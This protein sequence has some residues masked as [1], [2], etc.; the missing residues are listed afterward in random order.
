MRRRRQND[1]LPKYCQRRSYGVIYTP[2]LSKG[3][4]GKPINLGPSDM[5]VRDAW[6]AYERVTAEK[7]DTLNWLLSAYHDSERYRSRCQSTRDHYDAYRDKLTACPMANGKLFGG[8]RLEKIKRTSIQRYLDKHHAPILANRQIQYLKAAWNWAMNRY[9]HMPPNPCVGLELNV[10]KSRD[11]YIAPD[12]YAAIHQHTTG[13][14]TWAMELAY[15]C[16]AR[17]QEVLALRVR[18]M[19]PQGLR[20]IRSKGSKGEIT[21]W[22]PRLRAAVDGALAHS[23]PRRQPFPG[24]RLLLNNRGRPIGKSAWNSALQRLRQKMD[25]LGI[26]RFTLHD[27]KAAGYSDQRV[28]SAGHRSHKMHQVYDRKLRVVDPPG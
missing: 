9:D 17:R 28:Q 15:L 22:T 2:Y 20:L 10:H 11:R 3:R 24:D 23:Y 25:E 16:R 27:L 8:A 5:T 19:T 13:W 12:E 6:N 21:A 4:K 14:V 26:E 18:D 1:G 7:A